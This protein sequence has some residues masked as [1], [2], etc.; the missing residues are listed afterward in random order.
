MRQPDEGLWHE[1]HREV[2]NP[3]AGEAVSSSEASRPT[4]AKNC[5]GLALTSNSGEAALLRRSSGSSLSCL[6][7]N[8]DRPSAAQGALIR[9]R[10][11]NEVGARQPIDRV[12]LGS[13]SAALGAA[14]TGRETGGSSLSTIVRVAA[15]AGA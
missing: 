2:S 15:E 8:C 10:M 4:S 5:S 3:G 1:A 6:H 7:R 11:R 13:K 9:G 12:S 14:M